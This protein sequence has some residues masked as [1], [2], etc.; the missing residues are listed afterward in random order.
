MQSEQG[1]LAGQ[2]AEL[3][4]RLGEAELRA[5][6]NCKAAEQ[7]ANSVRVEAEFLRRK[8]DL[9]SKET[10]N[11]KQDYDKAIKELEQRNL[12]VRC[13][14]MGR[15]SKGGTVLKNLVHTYVMR[16]SDAFLL[17]GLGD[18]MK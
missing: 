11:R 2:Q 4:R 8:I 7:E 13:S 14:K 10:E 6:L 9:L 15:K 17:F 3:Q 16:L 18:A 5:D 1:R 12:E